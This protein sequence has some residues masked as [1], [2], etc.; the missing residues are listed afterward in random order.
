[1]VDFLALRALDILKGMDS[2]QDL[3]RSLTKAGIDKKALFAPSNEFV[4][5]FIQPDSTNYNF[6]VFAVYQ[7]LLSSLQRRGLDKSVVLVELDKMNYL[8][9]LDSAYKLYAFDALQAMLDEWKDKDFSV[10]IVN[11]I[12][13]F[14]ETQEVGGF[15]IEQE[16]VKNHPKTKELY[17]L[18][19][20]TIAKFPNY[21]RINLLKNKLPGITNPVFS[22][23]GEK[24]FAIS[25]KKQLSLEYRN[26]KQLKVKLYRVSSPLW[27]QYDYY[28]RNYL[29]DEKKTFIKEIVVSL[30]ADEPYTFYEDSFLV[31]IN[32]PGAYKLEFE[33]DVQLDPEANSEYYFSVTDL[34]SFARST[35]DTSREI[36]VV[37]RITGKPATNAKV[38]IYQRPNRARDTKPV[39]LKTIPVNSSGLAVIEGD[40][41]GYTLYYHAVVSNDNG[42]PLTGIPYNYY[43]RA[44]AD[45]DETTETISVFTDRSLYR[46]GQIVHFKAIAATTIDKDHSATTNKAIEFTLRDANNQEVAKQSLTTNEFGS[47][48]GEFV[49]PQGM[50]TGGFS[51]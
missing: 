4:E 6:H 39:L 16:G 31:S 14:Y 24:S 50:L 7:K 10:E 45:K 38:N 26:I 29:K 1:M 49:L 47:V 3:S 28:N 5:L 36:F 20:K 40:T 34:A 37:N 12:I 13:P 19:E 15:R 9:R 18:L 8:R 44:E 2:D 25:S 46:P 42:L 48:S 21:E 32:E 22:V 27:N 51:L 17:N 41:K 43:Q 23:E 35:S 30:K 33:A 11:E